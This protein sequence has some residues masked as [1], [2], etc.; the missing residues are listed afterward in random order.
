MK[1]RWEEAAKEF[2]EHIDNY[3]FD[4]EYRKKV[5]RKREKMEK[6]R[7]ESYLSQFSDTYLDDKFRVYKLY[8]YTNSAVV[9]AKTPREALLL[10]DPELEHW[11]DIPSIEECQLDAEKVITRSNYR[12]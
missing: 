3:M 11:S 8:N 1:N 5:D 12:P 9:I 10:Y 7:K 6:D 2:M 4:E